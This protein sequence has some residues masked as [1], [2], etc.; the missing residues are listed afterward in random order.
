MDG[1]RQWGESG[2]GGTESDGAG[3]PHAPQSGVQ[4]TAWESFMSGI[5][6]LQLQAVVDSR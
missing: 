4:L 5:C 2:Q 3:F 6:H 1:H